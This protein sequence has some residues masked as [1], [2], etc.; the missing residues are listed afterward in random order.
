MSKTKKTT[1]VNLTNSE[2]AHIRDL[3]S[4]LL[5]TDMKETVSQRLAV[6]NR[7]TLLE[8]KLWNKIAAACDQAGVTVGDDAPD[9]VVSVAS[10][11]SVSVFEIDPSDFEGDDPK[12]EG[13]VDDSSEAEEDEVESEEDDSEDNAVPTDH[14]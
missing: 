1:P 2:L 9:F 5:P 7:R 6:L 13:G 10:T 11:P 12:D 4:V 3:F 8:A 14:E